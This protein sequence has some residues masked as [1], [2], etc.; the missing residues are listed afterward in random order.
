MSD[1][2][3]GEIGA[4]TRLSPMMMP[5]APAASALLTLVWKVQ[6]PRSTKTHLPLTAPALV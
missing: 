1:V 6:K 2:P 4:A 3:D 5:T